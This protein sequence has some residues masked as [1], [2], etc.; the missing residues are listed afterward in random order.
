MVEKNKA[1]PIKS[2]KLAEPQLATSLIKNIFTDVRSAQISFTHLQN[3][4][5]DNVFLA[6]FSTQHGQQKVIVKEYLRDW[7]TRESVFYQKVASQ[8]LQLSAPNLLGTDKNILIL[9][10]LD[11]LTYRPLQLADLR[12]LREWI[13][14]KYNFFRNSPMLKYVSE[15][16]ETKCHYLINKPLD[17]AQQ[18]IEVGSLT[19]LKLD[20]TN[21][22]KS[23]T[24]LTKTLKQLVQL[25]QTLE[26]GD[27]EKQNIFVNRKNQQVM[28]I[29]WVNA[30]SGNGLLDINQYF[31]TALELN[32]DYAATSDIEYF[33]KLTKIADFD[34]QLR[35]F[36]LLMQLNKWH[37]YV[38]KLLLGENFSPNRL[39]SIKQLVVELTNGINRK[40]ITLL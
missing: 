17:L 6:E 10:Y 18:C 26:H 11:P 19:N 23:K 34:Q 30:K 9:E 3:G 12:T 22:P 16:F 32:N 8:V 2:A 31:E 38:S 29:D 15:S 24:R 21:W 36:Y 33:A 5:T 27:L 14:W 20:M 28:F 4:F 25:P 40:L 37:F 13:G 35:A 1:H 7:H 39:M